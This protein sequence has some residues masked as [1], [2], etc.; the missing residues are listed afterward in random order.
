MVS[1]GWNGELV[2]NGDRVLV[3]E[4]DRVLETDGVDGCTTV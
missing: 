1:G 4:D 3:G 2:L